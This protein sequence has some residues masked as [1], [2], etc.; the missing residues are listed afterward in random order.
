MN[1]APLARAALV[2]RWRT[3][4]A[5]AL[6][7]ALATGLGVGVGALERASRRAAAR[8]ADA[9][10]L[11]VGAPGGPTQL[12]LASVYLQPEALPLLDPA[13]T[14]RVLGEPDVVWSSPIGFGDSWR[15]YPVVGVAPAFLTFGGARRIA[16]GRGFEAEEEA[17]AGASVTAAVGEKFSPVHGMVASH[18]GHVHTEIGYRIVGRLPPTGT[19][20]DN[21]LLVPIESVWEVHGLGNGHPPGV[22]QVGPPWEQP[23][24]LPAIVLKPR[25]IAGAYLLRARYRSATSTAVF[26]GE[27]L[28]ALFRTLGD[29]R[30]VL[31]WMAAA[32]SGLVVV[33]VLLAFAGLVSGRAREH[34][35]L[36]AIGA[37]PGFIVAALW[38]ELGAIVTAGI[39]L[40]V[41][42]GW[43]G[44]WA[45][46]AG[47]ARSTGVAMPVWLGWPELS[48]A[49]ATLAACLAAAAA[50][51][52]LG[53]RVAPGA[54]LKQ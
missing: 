38:L 17:V 4:A 51:A 30:S 25:S 14:A 11:V 21:A 39:A 42:L 32:T 35:V 18:E 8:A 36:R 44:A 33:A 7:I 13:V 43:A 26:P 3:A 15:G 41:L 19:A 16:E 6:L 9:F 34:A 10:D 22:E 28:S 53:G 2:R 31:S 1:P 49:A 50:P 5:M 47:L 27:V 20:W 46:A 54:L 52:M 29:L 24:G 40:G 23:A 48:L 45:A 37:S 12:V